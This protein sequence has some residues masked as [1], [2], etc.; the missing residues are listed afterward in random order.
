VE[1]IFEVVGEF[2]FEFL[3]ELLCKSI[4][5]LAQVIHDLFR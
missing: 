2:L 5:L 3:I 1:I 4:L